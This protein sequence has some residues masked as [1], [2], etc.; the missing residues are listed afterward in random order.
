M[1]RAHI[2]VV[3]NNLADAT[4]FLHEWKFLGEE[5]RTLITE[6]R[7][8]YE[9][10]YRQVIEEGIDTGEFAPSDPKMAALLVL[11][12]VNW[13]PQWYNPDGPMSPQEVADIFSEHILRGLEPR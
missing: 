4:L 3:A 10:L 13:I 5:R 6:R 11:S 2:G 12:T 1:V 8:E 7:N 9:N